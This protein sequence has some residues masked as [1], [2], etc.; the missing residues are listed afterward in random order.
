MGKKDDSK[1]DRGEELER[2]V[3][4]FEEK[5]KRARADYQNL[6]KR[7]ESQ[8]RERALSASREL[9]IKLLPVGD[10][11]SLAARHLKDQGLDL[12]VR[13]FWQALEG[14]GLSEIK[15]EGREFDPNEMECV[16]VIEGGKEGKVAEEVKPGYCLMGK[17]LRPAQVKVFKYKK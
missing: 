5:W 13:Q 8:Q 9:I 17:I 1:L 11:F 10:S 6:E 16:E 3:K 4:E 2:L 14:E 7:V 12:A 15:V